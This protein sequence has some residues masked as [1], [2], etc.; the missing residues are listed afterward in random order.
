M[1][2]SVGRVVTG[3]QDLQ[4]GYVEIRGDRIDDVRPGVPP[5]SDWEFPNGILVPGFID[6][7]VNGAAGVDLLDCSEDD[8]ERLSVYL[9]STGTTGFLATFVSCAPDRARRAVGI[10]RW[11]HAAGAELL[12][13]HFEGPALNAVRRGA[14]EARW[15]RTP[16]DPEVRALYAQA[17]PD[18]RLVTLAPELPGADELIVQLTQEHVVVSAGHSDATYEQAAHAF[19]KGVRMVTHLFNA[20]RTFHHRDPGLVAAALDDPSCVCGLIADGVHVHP[21]VARC[22]YR[23]LGADRIALVTDA[24]AAAGMPPGEYT[25]AGAPI[26]VAA[27]GQPRLPDGT[28]AGSTLRMDTAVANAVRWG[29]PMRDAVRMA[30]AT[31]ARLLGL[32]DRGR[33][34]AG[35]RADLCVLGPDGRAALTLVA[36]RIVGRGGVA[37]PGP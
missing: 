26:F 16:D 30:A 34:E 10:L 25:L 27:D 23:L 5:S 18:L 17:S 20:M 2:L 24:V 12:G 19:G 32:S 35:M 15:L 37:L 7:Q 11:A 14:H 8:V 9:A 28:L 3:D 13:M 29:I 1:I 31:P 21:A 22:A 4:P 36:G 6:L 33:I